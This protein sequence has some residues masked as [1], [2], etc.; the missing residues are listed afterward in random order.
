MRKNIIGDSAKEIKEVPPEE[1]EDFMNDK[2]K[3]FDNFGKQQK[4]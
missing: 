3:L 4:R 1:F 2:E